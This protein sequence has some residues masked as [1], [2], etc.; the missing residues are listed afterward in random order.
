MHSRL[1]EWHFSAKKISLQFRKTLLFLWSEVCALLHHVSDITLDRMPAQVVFLIGFPAPE[2]HAAGVVV[3]KT[4]GTIQKGMAVTADS[5]F[6]TQEDPG[7]HWCRIL[8]V[9]SGNPQFSA[10]KAGTALKN[11]FYFFVR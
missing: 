11:M 8:R 2:L 9:K 10:F 3:N 4:A 7:I 1:R 6:I 5:V